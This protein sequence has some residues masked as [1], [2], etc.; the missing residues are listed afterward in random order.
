MALHFLE[1]GFTAPDL[2]D[3][4]VLHGLELYEAGGER[5]LRV[6]LGG[7]QPGDHII[8]RLTRRQALD[9]ASAAEALAQRVSE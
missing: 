1:H 8:A 3:P 5:F 2:N 7:R 6:W 4:H 9:L